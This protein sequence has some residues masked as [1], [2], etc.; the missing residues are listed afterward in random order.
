VIG[1]GEIGQVH[2]R[3]FAAARAAALVAISDIDAGALARTAAATG[4]NPYGDYKQLLTDPGVQVVSVCL[5]HALHLPV[6]LAAIESGKHVLIEKPLALTVSEADQ[7]IAA[8]AA[9]GTTVGLQH[10]QLFH[11][12]HVRAKELLESGILGRPV[13]IRLRLGIGGK[14]PGWRSDPKMTGGGLLHDAG[15]HRFYVARFLFGEVVEI[16][17]L[18]D[19]PSSEGEN[20]AIVALRFAN[21]ALGVI[22]ANYYGPSGMFDDAIEITCTDGALYVSGCEADFEGFRTGP[23][24]R[25]YDG[26]WHDEKVA[27]G[28][29][30][31]SVSASIAAFVDA[32][33]SSNP[34]PVTLA[35]GRRVL[36]IIESV[37]RAPRPLNLAP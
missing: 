28:N 26:A 15:V 19:K 31:D 12:P 29:W 32:V 37:D 35:E 24:L 6:T 16:V 5:P 13:H 7:I 23:A 20:Q 30:A 36:E 8:A 3:G 9:A 1:L 25:R 10:N 11:P 27:P 17:A 22:D 21:G 4:A 14:F 34:P 18:T 2:V 33:A